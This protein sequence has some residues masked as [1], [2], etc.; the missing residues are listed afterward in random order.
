MNACIEANLQSAR[1]I[2]I[3][4]K[5]PIEY[6]TSTVQ[7]L[8]NGGVRVV[9]VTLDSENALEAVRTLHERFGDTLMV[10]AGT[11]MTVAQAE[12]AVESGA[13]FLVSPHFDVELLR[14]ATDLGTCLIPGVLTP[15]EIVAAKK[16][17]A[18]V[19]K[20]FPAGSLGPAYI[21]DLLGPFAGTAFI[22][23]G[24]IQPEQ[25]HEYIR[26]GALAVGLGSA[27]IRKSDIENE[28][29]ETITEATRRL[30]QTIKRANG[31]NL[32]SETTGLDL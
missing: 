8:V 25:A 29:W 2:A 5:I 6:L 27:L 20:L 32:Y 28:N 24:G 21:K 15:S 31:G 12:Q 4:R 22:P 16:A 19:L 7:A 26:A 14:A 1:V 17:G 9:E 10:G 18:N 3:L 23:T 30:L 13:R 11:V